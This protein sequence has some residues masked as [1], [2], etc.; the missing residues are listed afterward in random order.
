MNLSNV[1]IKDAV[2]RLQSELH[3]RNIDKLHTLKSLSN[4]IMV[5][6]PIHKEGKERKPSCGIQLYDTDKSDKGTVHC[7]TCGFVSSFEEFIS[8]C[9]GLNDNGEFGKQWLSQYYSILDTVQRKETIKEL[10]RQRLKKEENY[11]SVLEQFRYYHPYMA[12]RKLTLDV[13]E[14]FDVGYDQ[15]TQCLTFPVRD[16]WGKLKFIARRSVNTHWFNYPESVEKPVYGLDLILKKKIKTVVVCES[17]INC[18][19]CWSYGKPAIALMGTGSENQYELLKKSGI[20]Q[21]ILAFDGDDAGDK[22]KR[23]FIKHLKKHAYITQYFLPR[24]KDINDLTKE[25]FLE[26]IEYTT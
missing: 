12:Q 13:I 21:Y 4:D 11:E 7:Y 9:F 3:L 14:L 20:R 8:V 17:F 2:E 25:E 24:G 15:I 22:G 26:L 10:T 18:L 19:N 16:E 6:C 23:E 1:D 5:T